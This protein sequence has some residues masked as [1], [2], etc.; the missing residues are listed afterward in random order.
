[1]IQT[2]T[3]ALVLAA[4]YFALSIASVAGQS[5]NAP[6]WRDR[7]LPR[8]Q[9]IYDRG[10]FRPAKFAASWLPDSTGY[11]VSEIDSQTKKS[12]L[13]RY[14]AQTG[15]RTKIETPPGKPADRPILSPD[16]NQQLEFHDNDLH[17]RN[18]DDQGLA[19]LTEHS[20]GR[21]ISYRNPSWSPD[22]QR[23]V[24]VE[25]DS[26]DVKRRS[27][28]V[29]GDPSYPT[30]RED[31]FARVGGKLP[32]L[33]VGIVDVRSGQTDWLIESPEEGFYLQQVEW[34]GNS[35]EILVEIQSRF[36]DKRQLLL[37]STDGTAKQ[38]FGETNKAWAV[39]SHGI[40]SG[41][42]W[43]RGGEAFIVISEKDGW[44][45]AYLCSRNGAQQ[46]KL[47][48]G[49]YD[50][51]NRAVIDEEAG[52][53]YFYASPE[54]GTQKYLYRVPL[55]G[56][57]TLQRVSPVDQPG[58]HDYD[59]SPNVQ[60]AIHTY[61]TINSPPIVELVE[62]PEHHLIRVFGG[63][64]RT[65]GKGGESNWAPDRVS[66][67]RHWRRRGDGR[68]ADKTKEFRRN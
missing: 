52:W 23:I 45:H 21:D 35:D 48:T 22:G 68:F 7:A 30:V 33:R 44:R 27:V 16:G 17:L 10:E 32:A 14:D 46:T 40:N 9:A 34:A 61:S 51:I 13:W 36:R 55:D 65:P 12:T 8:I 1:M 29:P 53:Y 42:E 67:D 59:F 19:Q 47:T 11:T 38:I 50:I 5:Q 66:A 54:N 60:W 3:F 62:L 4:V 2:P 43:I 39:G 57:G 20:A 63:Q 26:T 25:S 24:F 49:K 41:L 56:S 64:Q 18:L 37:V 58:T 15:E 31:V 28:L 6:T